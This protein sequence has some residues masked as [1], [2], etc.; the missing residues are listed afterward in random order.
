MCSNTSELSLNSFSWWWFREWWESVYENDCEN[1]FNNEFENV[2]ENDGED[3]DYKVKIVVLRSLL[4]LTVN[5]TWTLIHLALGWMQSCKYKYKYNCICHASN[6][7]HT[8]TKQIQIQLHLLCKQQFAYKT[9]TNTA[10][11]TWTLIHLT[12]GWTQSCTIV[13]AT[14]I[15]LLCKQL[16]VW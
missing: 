2:Y 14:Q 8:N 10:N 4:S 9:N 16:F 1:D 5:F 12:L 11:F 13:Q 3:E 7:L 6:N 15:E